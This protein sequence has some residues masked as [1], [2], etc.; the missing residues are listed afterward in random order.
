MAHNENFNNRVRSRQ[1]VS[2]NGITFLHYSIY[3]GRLAHYQ[4]KHTKIYRVI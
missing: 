2:Q 4:D 3:F 1:V